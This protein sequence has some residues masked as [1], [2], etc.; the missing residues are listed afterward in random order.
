MTL[1]GETFTVISLFPHQV[2]SVGPT[3]NRA[4]APSCVN[5]RD[6]LLL[7]SSST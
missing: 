2:R 4:G 1:N 5:R 7:H 3:R 6:K